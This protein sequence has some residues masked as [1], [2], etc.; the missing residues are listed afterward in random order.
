MSGFV[1]SP[2]IRKRLQIYK[3][4][5]RR[6]DNCRNSSRNIRGMRGMKKADYLEYTLNEFTKEFE[7][8][9]LRM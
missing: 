1:I 4:Q 3:S 9:C 6:K 8:V 5:R 7:Q 2:E